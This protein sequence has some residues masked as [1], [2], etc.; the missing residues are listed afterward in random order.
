MLAVRH[1]AAND[2]SDGD[3]HRLDQRGERRILVADGEYLRRRD[4]QLLL[5]RAV[6]RGRPR[7]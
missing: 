3:R 2:R 6:A 4:E 7:G 5:E 1:P